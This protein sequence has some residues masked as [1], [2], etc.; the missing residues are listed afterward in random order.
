MRCRINNMKKPEIL[1]PAGSIQ[2]LHAAVNAG[3]DAVY[4]GGSR[5][6]ARAYAGNFDEN[7]LLEGIEFS[8]LHGVKVY[9]TVNTLFRNEEIEELYDYLL[10]YYKAGL[11]AVIVQDFGVMCF[12]HTHF[13]NL[14]IHASTQMTITTPYAYEI[15]KDYGVTRIVPARELSIDEIKELKNDNKPEVE[16]FVQ[17]ALCICYSGQCLMSSYIGGRSGNRGRCAGSCRLPYSVRKMTDTPVNTEGDYNLSMKDLCGLDSLPELIYAGVDS[18]KIEGRMKSP[19]YV[20]S[21]VRSYR[22]C[23]DHL[24]EHYGFDNLENV[25]KYIS[26][27]VSYKQKYLSFADKC[28]QEMAEVFNRGGFTPGYFHKK[29]GKDMMSFKAPGHIGVKLADIKSIDNNRIMLGLYMDVNKGDILFIENKHGEEITLTS[30]VAERSGHNIWL[31]ASKVK[32]LKPGMPVYRRFN[33]VLNKELEAYG[34]DKKIIIHGEVTLK[35]DEGAFIRL[36]TINGEKTINVTYCGDVVAAADNKPISED[37]VRDK[38]TSTGNE[39]FEFDKLLLNMDKDVFLPVKSIKEL[40]RNAFKALSKKI[41]ETYYREVNEH[42]NTKPFEKSDFVIEKNVSGII[43]NGNST[44]GFNTDDNNVNGIDTDNNNANNINDY[45][46]VDIYNDNKNDKC[47]A[48][49]VLVSDKEQLTAISSYNRELKIGVDLQFFDKKDIIASMQNHPD[50][51]YALPM[52]LRKPQI[53]EL[54]ALPLNMCSSLI[55]RNVDELAYL[56]EIGYTGEIITDYS[57]Y[58]MN[59]IAVDY[60][61]SL[62]SDAVITLPVELNRK[63]IRDYENGGFYTKNTEK[64]SISYVDDGTGEWVVYGHQPLMVMAECIYDNTFGCSKGSNASFIL[65]DRK[66]SSFYS[67]AVCKYCCNIIYNGIPTV[68]F[69]MKKDIDEYKGICRLHFT[70]ESA[71]RVKEILDDFFD[72]NEYDGE[73]TRG[74]YKRGVE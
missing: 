68:L 37:F 52:I 55:V 3:A 44:D 20:A 74:H 24:Y 50:Y 1:A 65:R 47:T 69:D 30:N 43:G 57:L 38:L 49:R 34:T 63:Q 56:Y 31:N 21:C 17:G 45:I 73:F 53:E 35:K 19:E 6:G 40:R 58:S 13:P 33:A 29:N 71:D 62:F 36:E 8:H 14:P 28:R 11:D 16:V 61:R 60:I 59:R 46:N 15:L 2:A 27:N 26:E 10:P 4:L 67:K 42:N 9:L 23:V 22:S 7:E 72:G 48:V 18:F 32:S 41:C 51:S 54:K 66:N 70:Y 39:I 12:I 64:H 5:F 25:E